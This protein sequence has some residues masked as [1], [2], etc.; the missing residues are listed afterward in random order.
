MTTFD[1]RT[2]NLPAIN[3]MTKY[4]SI[5]TYH[6]LDPRH[7]GLTEEVIKFTGA[8]IGT[9]KVDGTNGRIILLPDRTYLIGSR[10]E[11]LYAKGDLI[12]NPSQG[13]VDALR[14]V[15]DRVMRTTPRRDAVVVF[16][17]EVYGGKIGG[18]ARQYTS[19]GAVGCRLFDV[20][21]ISDYN[22]VLGW[23]SA[24]ISGWRDRG[25]QT[26]LA[27]VALQYAAAVAGLDLT[28]RLFAVDGAD[29][30]TGIPETHEFLQQQLPHTLVSLD[31]PGGCRGEGIVLRTPDRAQAAKARFQ[32]YER[33]LR[34]RK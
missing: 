7:G 1:V 24:R 13:I 17:L 2:T 10:E 23:D 30:P 9:E 22:T 25:G 20:A 6:T 29:L 12:G 18:N 27:E 16:Y 34:R 28:P 26:Y 14:R 8:V 15:A 5:P 4:P 11:L 32:D 19:A 31:G 3:S 33:T 21:V